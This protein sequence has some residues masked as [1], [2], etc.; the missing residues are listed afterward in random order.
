MSARSG[1]KKI[2]TLGQTLLSAQ[3]SRM[4]AEWQHCRLPPKFVTQLIERYL[5]RIGKL[6]TALTPYLKR[7]RIRRSHTVGHLLAHLMLPNAT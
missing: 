7:I 4:A 1:N 2:R 5:A 6:F 3:L